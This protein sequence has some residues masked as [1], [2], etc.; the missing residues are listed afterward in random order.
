MDTSA[1]HLGGEQLLIYGYI[2]TGLVAGY[3]A[4]QTHT[5]GLLFVEPQESHDL[6][7]AIS[8]HRFFE[9]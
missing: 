5:S 6:S 2:G 4:L 1:P 9:K 7:K 8:G 3:A